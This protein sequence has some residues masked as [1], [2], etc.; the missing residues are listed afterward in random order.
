M[1]ERG[2]RVAP[3]GDPWLAE[4]RCVAA[5]R[6]VAAAGGAEREFLDRAF[7]R[8][9]ELEMRRAGTMRSVVGTCVR[10]YRRGLAAL[11]RQSDL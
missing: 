6:A 9:C 2:A 7:A 4:V 8:V 10:A 3:D 5:G 11:H 1:V